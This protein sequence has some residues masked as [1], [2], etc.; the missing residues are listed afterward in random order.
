[1]KKRV[2]SV[3][4][5]LVIVLG[6]VGSA[7]ADSD[8]TLITASL[9]TTVLEDYTVSEIAASSFHRAALAIF[10]ALDLGQNDFDLDN[11]NLDN[12]CYVAKVDSETFEVF[13]SGSGIYSGKTVGVFWNYSVVG[14][15]YIYDSSISWVPTL[16]SG[17]GYSYWKVDPDDMETVLGIVDSVISN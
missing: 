16:S 5:V 12:D 10:L 11:I 15:Y 13:F 14:G 7:G 2:L 17:L 8:V 9:T 3:L 6:C 1:M 4:L